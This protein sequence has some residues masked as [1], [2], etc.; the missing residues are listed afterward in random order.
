MTEGERVGWHH[1]LD[2]RESEQTPGDGE[3]QRGLACCSPWGCR[4]GHDLTTEQQQGSSVTRMNGWVSPVRLRNSPLLCPLLVTCPSVWP[5]PAPER[6]PA[7]PV[8]PADPVRLLPTLGQPL[9]SDWPPL[10][11]GPQ[12]E[13]PVSAGS[14]RRSCPATPLIH[15]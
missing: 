12:I 6:L 14:P 3:G 13:R 7:G 1:R 4:V 2:G 5:H 9:L 15:R 11:C 10:F 8:A